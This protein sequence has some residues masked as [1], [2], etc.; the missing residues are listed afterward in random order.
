MSKKFL[1][2]LFLI[3]FQLMFAQKSLLKDFPEGYT[4]K[5]IGKR[6]AYRF[7]TEKHALHVGKWIGYPETFYW[8]GALRYADG[9]KDKELIQRLQEKFDFLFTEE[10]I[11]QPIMNHVDLNMFGSL[12]L[13]FYLVTKDLKYRYLG[14]PYADSQWELPRNAKPHEKEWAEKGY[15]W[16]T[17]LW[18]DDMYMITIV[19]AEAYHVTGDKKYIN[20]AAKEMV[21][22]LDEIQ[23]ENGLFYHAPDVP[24]YWGRGDGWMAVGMTELLFN[25]PENDPNRQRILKGYRLMMENLKKYVNEDGLWNQL[26]DEKDC[27][28]ETSGSAMFTYAMILGVKN[29]WLDKDEYGPIARRAWLGLCNYLDDNNDLMEVCIG[30][31]KKNSHQYYLDRPRITGDYHG[32]APIIWCAYALLSE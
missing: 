13:E 28:T 16:Q 32:Q 21:L 15:S 4:P 26:I 22:Y 2:L 7:L 12:P 5:E 6:I 27:W 25:L 17:R 30:T 23:R 18:I 8:S 3:P 14:L 9:A 20:R 11:L 24:F 29:G 31:G 10:K 19:Q 1:I